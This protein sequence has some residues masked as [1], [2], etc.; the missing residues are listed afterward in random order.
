MIFS[1]RDVLALLGA[2]TSFYF[3]VY[4]VEHHINENEIHQ[5]YLMKITS[6]ICTV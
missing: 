3:K 2:G 1:E 6:D 4:L 5:K